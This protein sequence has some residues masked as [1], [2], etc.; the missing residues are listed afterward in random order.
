MRILLHDAASIRPVL[1]AHAAG[2]AHC[3]GDRCQHYGCAEPGRGA[4]DGGHPADVS[5]HQFVRLGGHSNVHS[6]R[7]PD[8]PRQSKRKAG[9]LRR[10]PVRL[11]AWWFVAGLG[12]GGNVLRCDFRLRSGNYRR[13]RIKPGAGIAQERL[14]P[15]VC[16]KFNCRKRHP[17]RGDPA[18]GAHDYL[19]SDCP[20]VG[21]RAV[22][23][24]LSA[25]AGYGAGVDGDCHYPGL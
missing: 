15:C 13:G 2:C 17:W 5:G 20:A 19:C 25:G 4:F 22:P 7:R 1:R 23:E 11:S 3:S 10:L 14:R 12:N 6:G 16:R 18:F 21:N 9:Q 24:R 8:G